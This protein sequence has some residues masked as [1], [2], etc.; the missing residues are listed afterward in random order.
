MTRDSLLILYTWFIFNFICHTEVWQWHV[1]SRVNNGWLNTPLSLDQGWKTYRFLNFCFIF[2]FSEHLGNFWGMDIL[3]YPSHLPGSF[4]MKFQ[5]LNRNS[6]QMI[7]SSVM[8]L[9]IC[10]L[11]R[12]IMCEGWNIFK[13]RI[14]NG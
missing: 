4:C 14:M 6:F 3:V 8:Y 10:D 7:T 2:I 12:C 11:L 13:T 1:K 9:A 5:A